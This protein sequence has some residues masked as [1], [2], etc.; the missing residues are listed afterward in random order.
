VV[1]KLEIRRK[2]IHLFS[3]VIPFG[4]ALVSKKTA[5]IALIGVT[6][7][8]LF[9]DVIRY[10]NE[11]IRTIYARYLIGT[12]VR[13]KEKNRLIGST[14]FS[15]GACLCVWLFDKP[16]AILSLLVLIIPDTVAALVG[17]TIGR[18]PIFGTKTLEGSVAFFLSA[19]LIVLLF[20]GIRP[21]VGLAAAFMATLAE[22]LPLRIDDNLLIPLVMGFSI[23]G[24]SLVGQL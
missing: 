5:V 8:F 19:S 13:E 12:V 23:R 11:C 15:L 22:C 9:F 21:L 24:F 18:T 3:L 14:Y 6:A 10:Y 20:P 7:F 16:V 1:D 17:G 2:A 4:Y